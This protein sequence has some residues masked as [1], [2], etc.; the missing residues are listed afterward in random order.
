MSHVRL[1]PLGLIA[2]VPLLMTA[3]PVDDLEEEFRHVQMFVTKVDDKVWYIQG[4][5]GNIAV[6]A[7]D[8]SALPP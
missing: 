4:R 7:G 2:A 6:L 3:W 5:G 1:I 8:D